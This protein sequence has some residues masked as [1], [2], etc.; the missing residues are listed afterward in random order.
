[1]GPVCHVVLAHPGAR[2]PVRAGSAQQAVVLD[3]ETH[4]TACHFPVETGEDLTRAGDVL[5]DRAEPSLG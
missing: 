2:G 3:P 5:R 1:V 4:R